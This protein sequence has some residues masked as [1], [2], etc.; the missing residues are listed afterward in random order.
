MTQEGA[1]RSTCLRQAW[2]A[3]P[4][5]LGLG[6]SACGGWAIQ[7]VDPHQATAQVSVHS[8]HVDV[9][10]YETTRAPQPQQRH[11]PTAI[12]TASQAPQFAPLPNTVQ[13]PSLPDRPV[14]Y[15]L[16]P[17]PVVDT[18]IS[19]A[20]PSAA[21]QAPQSSQPSS[22]YWPNAPERLVAEQ[23]PEWRQPMDFIPPPLGGDDGAPSVAASAG[24]PQRD[25]VNRDRRA[26]GAPNEP[27]VY[28]GRADVPLHFPPPQ[29]ALLGERRRV[30]TLS[31]RQFSRPGSPAGSVSVRPIAGAPGRVAMDAGTQVPVHTDTF[32]TPT[33]VSGGHTE[34]VPPAHIKQA[35]DQPT[36]LASAA[37][38]TDA[39]PSGPVGAF[40]LG[41]GDVISV[42]VYSRP[43]L[44]TTAFVSDRGRVILPLIGEVR[45]SG[46]A[47]AE[48]SEH[49]AR[50]YE[51][52]EFLVNPQ[53]NVV[54]SE[55][56]SQQISVLGEVK[57]PGRFPVETRL[58]VL[59]ALALAGGLNELAGNQVHV[60]R[61]TGTGA[62]SRISV[63]MTAVMG[64]GRS[65]PMFELRAGDTVVAPKSETFYIY[66][67]VRQPSAYRLEPGMTV[68]QALSVSGGLTE[69]GSDKRVQI[70]RK[71]T[72]GTLDSLQAELNT[73]IR[74]DDV[75]YVKERLF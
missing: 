12:T 3:A 43:E 52:G 25:V 5:A 61:P 32:P 27:S 18:T 73:P 64:G 72:D 63:D 71:R 65:G 60:L 15:G 62:S 20:E 11:D 1:I 24:F 14:I 68:I 39:Y 26:M 19:A 57:N 35:G 70:K 34:F 37:H 45:V 54:V 74:P 21:Q 47:P 33:I 31:R 8:S 69:R 16:P 75:I 22:P 13:I 67:E 50:A 29:V 49:I 51:E 38:P 9:A 23:N 53:V 4:V 55:Y 17:E 58:T 59:D 56:R 48:A 40:R 7:E 6:L 42:Q 2:L 66:G 41:P 10:H 44:D 36:L 28:D 46:L 30:D